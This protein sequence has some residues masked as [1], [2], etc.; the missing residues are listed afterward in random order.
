MGRGLGGVLNLF[1]V[2]LAAKLLGSEQFGLFSLSITVMHVALQ[3]A[4]Q[5]IDTVLVRFY[6]SHV[7]EKS[8]KKMDVL[9]SSLL[10]RIVLTSVTVLLGILLSEIYVRVF[11]RPEL[12]V[13]F[14]FGFGGCGIASIWYYLLAVLQAK[15]RYLPHSILS[16]GINLL[17]VII[18]G[19]LVWMQ[20]HSLV[21][22][23]SINLVVFLM[24]AVIATF[25]MPRHLL[26]KNTA[27]VDTMKPMFRYGKWVMFSGLV[28]ILYSRLDIIFLST[29]RSAAE[30]GQYSA[31]VSMITG[32][33][34]IILALFT[35]FLPNASKIKCYRDT[36]SYIKFS[37]VISSM[38]LSVLVVFYFFSETVILSILGEEYRESIRVFKIVFPGFLTYLFTFPWA[39]I[40]YSYNKPHLL[41][42]SDVIV[43]T[44]FCTAGVWLIPQFGMIG[45]AWVSF[46]SRV[47][48]SLVILIL[49]AW[50]SR[51]LRIHKFS[52]PEGI[53]EY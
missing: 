20:M 4:G 7:Q 29:F 51:L 3:F 14:I 15:E 16:G 49:V 11:D 5:G 22:L 26:K 46:A 39:L 32:L 1:F 19:V 43:L 28:S 36:I 30:T 9:Q 25:L 31:A 27:I 8:G 12:R 42:M 41:F 35:V 21:P 23:L 34:L 33:D 48:N 52:I 18:L 44:V 17:K 10:I 45:A 2:I 38:V 53:C 13:A 40:I 47:V 24:G 50:Q 37:A 6:V